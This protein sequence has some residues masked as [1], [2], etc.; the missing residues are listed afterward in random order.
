MKVF[1]F[2]SYEEFKK[3]KEGQV[4]ENNTRH[5]GKTN[6]VGFCFL[7]ADEIDIKE[8]LHFLSGI[9]SFDIC[10]VFETNK[11]LNKTYGEYAKPIK[12]Y[13]K[14][15]PFEFIIDLLTHSEDIPEN[16]RLINEYCTKKYSK[17]D[18]KL[19]KYSEN[20]WN[21]WNIIDHQKELIWKEA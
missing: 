15:N 20:I 12:D 21:Q 1:R 19:I 4:L 16:R 3:Y 17:A 9:A 13:D 18:F 5:I 7:D 6:S 8:A 11:K 10:A 2:M 14:K